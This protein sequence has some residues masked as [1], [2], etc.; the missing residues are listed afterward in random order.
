ME[1][2]K[3]TYNENDTIDCEIN[4]PEYGWIPFTADPNDCEENGRKIYTEIVEGKHGV[5]SPYVPY[6]PTDEEKA[7]TVRG[8]RDSL[9]K[10]LD[11]V[12]ANPLRWSSFS[13]DQQQNLAVY[14]QELLD[15]PQ[16]EGFP[17]AVE[18]PKLPIEV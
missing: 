9:L 13:E 11:A 1:I 3:P 2:R 15:V 18:W 4:H 14:R 5:I 8:E 10:E 7:L 6:V 17:E 16:Q 12:T